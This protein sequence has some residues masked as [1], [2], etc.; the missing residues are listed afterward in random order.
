MV[1]RISFNS[2]Y[3]IGKAREHTNKTSKE[4]LNLANLLGLCIGDVTR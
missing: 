4:D 3:Q 1:P 2:S